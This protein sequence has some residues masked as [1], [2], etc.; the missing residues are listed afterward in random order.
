MYPSLTEL[1]IRAAFPTIVEALRACEVSAV[2]LS[3][4]REMRVNAVDG[5]EPF[6]LD[7]PQEVERYRKH[8]EAHRVR[9]AGFLLGPAFSA[10]GEVTEGVEW[11]VRAV[12]AAEGLGMAAIRIDSILIGDSREVSVSRRREIFVEG[13]LRVLEKTPESSI[14]LGIENHGAGGNNLEF[15]EGVFE[16]VGSER[17]GSTMDMGNFYWSGLPL[18][19]VYRVLERLAPRTKHTH[20]KNIRYPEEMREVQRPVGWEY[21]RYC[22]PLADGD[23]D[24]KRVIGFLKEAGYQ[25][26]LSVEDESLGRFPPEQRPEILKQDAAFLKATLLEMGIPG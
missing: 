8:L 5:G 20:V 18:S 1:S 26:D 12:R 9:P 7:S 23:I 3:L 19:E 17:I 4:S 21:G 22:C 14:G 16:G 24:L 25:G 11:I 6:V 2:E 10:D 15:L 13:L